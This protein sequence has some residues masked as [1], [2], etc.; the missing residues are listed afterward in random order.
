[1]SNR[2][3]I[4][5]AGIAGLGAA[6]F[7][8]KAGLEPVVLEASDRLGGRAG[9]IVHDGRSYEIGGKN[10][11]SDWALFNGI[12]RS[13]HDGVFD[14][15][16][17][18]FHI[19]INGRLVGL[20]KKATLAGSIALARRIGV[21]PALRFRRLMREVSERRGQL[22]YV[23]EMIGDLEASWDERPLAAHMPRAL[24]T[25]PL[26]MFTVIMGAAEPDEFSLATLMLLLASFGK[27]SHHS[28]PQTTGHLFERL[29]SECDVRLGHRVTRIRDER[30]CVRGI[31]GEGPTGPFAIDAD[32]VILAT[33]LHRWPVLMP[34]DAGLE[35][36]VGAIPYY[37][38]ALMNAD[39]E[40]EVF[41]PDMNSIMFD[42]ASPLGHCS[43]NRTY[44]RH[45]VRFTLSGRMARPLLREDDARLADRA[46]AAFA[47]VHPLPGQPRFVHVE[48]HLGGICAYGFHYSRSRR[49]LLAGMERI[50]GLALAGDYLF[51]HNMEGC[52]QSSLAA[53][54]HLTGERDAYASTRGYPEQGL[55]ARPGVDASG[56]LGQAA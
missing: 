5:G 26:R 55:A 1:M 21:R 44:R 46:Q 29:A 33:P 38:L 45:S 2:V 12:L 17:P 9:S 13:F 48:R 15:Q 56:T 54:L 52:L 18:N 34:L 24:A 8:R 22:G 20:E 27:G 49:R 32:R 36:A 40:R 35:D 30:G 7:A 53:V 6:H 10:F 50:A 23:G 3:Y 16:H 14:D 4:I 28:L 11:A 39:Y 51:G 25:G 47:R 37:P 19:V 43:A 41:T 31:D 42:P